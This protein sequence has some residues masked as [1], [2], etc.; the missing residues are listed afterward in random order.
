MLKE[1]ESV[2]RSDVKPCAFE[3]VTKEGIGT[4][5]FKSLLLGLLLSRMAANYCKGLLMSLARDLIK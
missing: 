2:Q 3:I 4:F 1:I 5:L